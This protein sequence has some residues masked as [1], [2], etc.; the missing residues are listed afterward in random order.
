MRLRCRPK[1]IRGSRSIKEMERVSGVSRATL[2]QIENGR[3]LPPDRHL[4]AIET[5]YGVP[6]EEWYEPRVLLVIQAEDGDE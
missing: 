1:E 4:A 2:S 6:A 3:M 5:A